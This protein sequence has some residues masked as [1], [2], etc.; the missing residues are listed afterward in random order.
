MGGETEK[1]LYVGAREAAA[2]LGVKLPTLYAYVSRGW[3]RSES[4]GGKS[5]AR[6]YRVEDVRRLKE[7]AQGRRDPG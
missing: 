1:A 2:E 5:R 3:I 4:V 7:R 6:R